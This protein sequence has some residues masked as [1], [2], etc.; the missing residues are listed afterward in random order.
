MDHHTRTH[1]GIHRSEN[2]LT[3][4]YMIDDLRKRLQDLI[5]TLLPLPL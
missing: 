3:T 5:V 4:T 2:T 1:D